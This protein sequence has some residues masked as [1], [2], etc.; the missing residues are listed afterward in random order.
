MV[1]RVHVQGR[2]LGFN[3]TGNLSFPLRSFYPF[4]EGVHHH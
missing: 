3:C 4:T 1:Q 2:N